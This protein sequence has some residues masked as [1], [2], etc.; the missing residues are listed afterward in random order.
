M[1]ARHRSVLLIAVI[2][3]MILSGLVWSSPAPAAATHNRASQLTW[4]KGTG[5]AADF[6]YTASYRRSY[7]GAPN[8]GDIVVDA[9]I[10][11]GD[12]VCETPDLTVTS[13]DAAN[14]VIMVEAQV[15]HTYA[16]NGPFTASATGCCRLSPDNGHINNPDLAFSVETIVDLGSTTA[17]PHSTI[18]PIV[19]CPLNST[20]TFT[21]PAVD[22]DHQGLRYRMA[23]AAETGDSLF[24][25]PGPPHATNAATIDAATGLYSWNT[26]GATLRDTATYGAG[27]TY[28]STQVVVENVVSGNVVSKIAVDFF[29]RL[30]DQASTNHSPDFTTP[31]PA[32]GTVYDICVGDHLTFDVAASDQ[33]PT[34]TVTLGLIGKPADATFTTTSGNPATGTFDFTPT[35]TGNF[36]MNLTA[37]DQTGHGAVPRSVTINV[38]AAGT[39]GST[40]PAHLTLSKTV[41][42]TGG[43]TA[44]AT[45]WTLTA[46]G[47]TTISGHT[48]DA[49]ITSATVQAGTYTLSEAGPSGY[50]ASAWA[51]TGGTLT[52]ATLVL[53]AGATASCTIANTFGASSPAQL[54]LV[55]TVDNT[56]GG[57][58]AAI[59]WTLKARGPTTISGHTGDATITNA[60]VTPGRY[61]LSESGPSGYT[62]SNWSCTGG[63]S[64]APNQ[65]GDTVRLASG[66]IVTCTINNT[67][68]VP[69]AASYVS[70]LLDR[71]GSMNDH[72]AR[73]IATF[74][75]WLADEQQ[76]LPDAKATLA[77]FNSCGYVQRGP[78]GR[79]I[80]NVPDL[81]KDNYHG[82]CNTPLYDAI[83][84]TINRT[85]RNPLSA[86]GVTIVVYTDG[87]DTA[88]KNWTRHEVDAL[89]ADKT[90]QGWTFVWLGNSVDPLIQKWTAQQ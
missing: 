67:Y 58:A 79:P 48:G 31:T 13:V 49:S 36:P 90:A 40:G 70:I 42:N 10:C 46:T 69:S 43:G 22:P 73:T 65:T 33:D 1:R 75:A 9:Q 18:P 71:S 38:A 82:R 20:C 62:A 80:G 89:I 88:S 53:A 72:R 39:C 87:Q 28:Y 57:T 61:R 55:K 78:A 25:Q 47:P 63:V 24:V 81:T 23:T 2:L 4:T 7:F 19:D 29:I 66:D 14:D 12:G 30:T 27:D 60:A 51:C 3:T 11:Y 74:N 84:K 64:A 52:G 44:A 21:V 85:A 16:G 56:G 76:A 54:T 45:D 17:S 86:G 26:T 34:D 37:Q 5:T 50:S 41:D 59:D 15:S 6:D 68:V 83:A 32:D 8:V 77:L 35:A